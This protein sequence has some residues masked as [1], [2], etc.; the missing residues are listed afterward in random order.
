MNKFEEERLQA[1]VDSLRAGTTP[2][3]IGD[4]EQELMAE[5]AVLLARYPD[6]IPAAQVDT[7]A[8][9]LQWL[10]DL[11]DPALG[12]APS[13]SQPITD[14]EVEKS[15]AKWAARL[16]GPPTP[17]PT[18][19]GSE[20]LSA[21][22]RTATDSSQES[23]ADTNCVTDR[24][25]PEGARS[26]QQ[27][28][29]STLTAGSDDEASVQAWAPTPLTQHMAAV[30]LDLGI[31]GPAFR[32]LHRVWNLRPQAAEERAKIRPA[33]QQSRAGQFLVSKK[34]Q[35]YYVDEANCR[36]L[37]NS[38]EVVPACAIDVYL[39]NERPIRRVSDRKL[40]RFREGQPI[41][42]AAQ[43]ATIGICQGGLLMPSD[44][45]VAPVR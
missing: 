36:R 26:K 21:I 22:P 23:T 44:N 19:T 42:T 3:W 16:N 29:Q 27:T 15:W 1:A 41:V 17:Q 6:L 39:Y 18:A 25:T 11:T 30:C 9:I 37:L 34:R 43:A 31:P 12:G 45:V 14:D 28:V 13:E 20:P 2:D 35:V 8:T 24:A 38:L 7:P 10:T 40:R 4:L 33:R 5:L 32:A